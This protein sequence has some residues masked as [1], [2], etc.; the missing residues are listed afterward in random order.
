RDSLP[1]ISGAFVPFSEN[2]LPCGG[3]QN[4]CHRHIDGLADHFA[5]VVDDHHGA[6][7]QVGYALVVF[8]AFLEDEDAHG[9]AGQHDRLQRVRELVDIQYLHALQLRHLVQV[10]VVGDDLAFV[11]L[12]QF[13]QLEINYPDSGKI[14]FHDLNLQVCDLLQALENIEAPAAAIPLQRVCRIGDQLQLAQ[15]E[16]RRNNDAVE[17]SGL[18]NVG[19]SSVDDDAGIENLVTLLSL[20]LTAEDS[21]Q[22]SQIQQIALVGADGEADVCHQ[23]HDQNLEEALGVSRRNAAADDQRE[24]IRPA[25]AE[26]ASDRGSDQALETDRTQLPL[27]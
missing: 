11:Q 27:E 3:L 2:H 26:D 6:V 17:K 4:G 14:V 7:I 10:E 8:L 5:R 13:D 24:K 22:G 12:G 19:N 23:E 15:H 25:D 20:L 16:L 18:G 21:T 9:F 1:G